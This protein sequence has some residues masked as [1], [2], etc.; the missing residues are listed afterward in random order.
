MYGHGSMDYDYDMDPWLWLWLQIND[1]ELMK[2]R[3]YI[4]GYLAVDVQ[5]IANCPEQ[6]MQWG[7]AHS[8]LRTMY[9]LQPMKIQEDHTLT[10]HRSLF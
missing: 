9:K 5:N 6:A 3:I 1:H 10:E 4:H 8:L 2:L 7:L